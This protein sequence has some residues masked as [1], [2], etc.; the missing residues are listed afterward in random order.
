MAH[1]NNAMVL[2]DLWHYEQWNNWVVDVDN[3]NSNNDNNNNDEIFVG[4]V[5]APSIF[6][7][8]LCSLPIVILSP[9]ILRIFIILF[10]ILPQM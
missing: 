3:N 8:L 9:I 10:L 1:F 2:T 5:S 6:C 4:R 7:A